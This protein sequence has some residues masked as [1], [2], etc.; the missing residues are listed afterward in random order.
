M[1]TKSLLESPERLLDI[2]DQQ[3][4]W[5]EEEYLSLT[6]HTSRL[7]E[8]TDGFLEL[9]P[10]P[11]DYHQAILQLLLYAFDAFLKP[12]GGKVRIAPLRLRIGKG[13]FREPDL[14][15]LRSAA[16][17]RRQDRFWTG[18]DLVVEVVSP[19]KPERDLVAKR[20]DYAAAG[21]AEYW[22]VNPSNETILV[23]VLNKKRYRQLGCFVRGGVA[24]SSL[25]QGFQLGV[26]QVF[27][28]D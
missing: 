18:A 8:F 16:D 4:N 14:L 21:V 7:V 24:Q 3:G 9:L 11:T 25:L 1:T 10:M 12:L 13:K 5:T 15:L 2:L 6:D 20:Q 19:D 26:D 28:A 17:R 22:I 23:L 27:D